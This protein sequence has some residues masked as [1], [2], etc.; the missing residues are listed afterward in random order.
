[1]VVV[2][3]FD[4]KASEDV[5]LRMTEMRTWFPKSVVKESD[6]IRCNVN[7]QTLVSLNVYNSPSNIKTRN[8]LKSSFCYYNS[9]IT[10]K[11]IVLPSSI[12]VSK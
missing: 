2:K 8:K 3:R 7:Y 5:T 6:S 4:S 11:Q 9:I 12:N 10:H 1:M